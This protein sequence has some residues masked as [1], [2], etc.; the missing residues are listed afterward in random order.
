MSAPAGGRRSRVT[1]AGRRF[2]QL[3]EVGGRDDPH[4]LYTELRSDEPVFWSEATNAWVLMRYDDVRR[5]LGTESDFAVLHGEAGATIHGKSLLQ[6]RGREHRHKKA[7]IAREIRNLDRLDRLIRPTVEG[8][9]ADLVAALRRESGP[10]DMRKQFTGAVPLGVISSLLGVSSPDRLRGWYQDLALAG[11]E[12]LVGDPA[13]EAR[14]MAALHR[15]EEIIAPVIAAQMAQPSEG[16]LAALAR[17]ETDGERMSAA[18]LTTLAGFLLTAGV[19]TTDRTLA[20]LFYRLGRYPEEWSLLQDRH[21]LVV[22]VLAEVL[23]FEP[24]VHG[25][26]RMALADTEFGGIEIEKGERLIGLI[27]SANRDET[28]FDRAD[29]F[30]PARFETSADKQ[31]TPVSDILTFGAGAHHC[32]GSLLAKLE[33]SIAVESV[34]ESFD[35]IVLESESPPPTGVML[36]APERVVARLAA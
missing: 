8:I 27:G 33:M 25:I 36:R 10:I 21:D 9:V 14:G 16:V 23:R 34:L 30:D 6:M 19:E 2:D 1:S 28:R 26:G 32:T 18:E 11:V 20:S 24:A 7:V 31:F 29:Q 5:V 35:S 22:P 3:F 12:N 13:V 17:L 4:D 15:F